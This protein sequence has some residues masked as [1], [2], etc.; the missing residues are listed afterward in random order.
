MRKRI[1]LMLV[2]TFALCQSLYAAPALPLLIEITQPDGSIIKARQ[3]GDEF[4]HWTETK[5]GYTI[6]H[7]P[8]TKYWEYAEQDAN[9]RLKSSGYRAMGQE[10]VPTHIPPRLKPPRNKKLELYRQKSLN[11]TYQERLKGAALTPSSSAFAPSPSVQRAAVGDWTPMP[12]A[13]ERKLLLVL[14]NFSDRIL[15][16]DSPDWESTVFS[17]DPTDKSVARYFAENS[18]SA[19]NVSPA[20]HRQ[21]D[22]PP[23]IIAVSI[24]A[25]HPYPSGDRDPNESYATEPGILNLALTQAATDVDFRSFD[26]DNSGTLEQSEL[27][28]YFIYAGYEASGSDKIPSVWAHAWGESGVTAGGLAVTDWAISGELNDAGRQQTMG[29]IAHELGHALCGL[30]DLYDTSYTNAGMGIFSLM[31]AGGWGADSSEDD[32]TTPTNLDLWS[33]EYLGWATAAEPGAVNAITIHPSLSAPDSGYKLQTPVSDSEYYLLENRHPAGWDLG[34]KFA[35]GAS[36]QGGLLLTHIDITAGT[37]GSNDINNFTSTGGRQGVS[38]VQASTEI[39]DMLT[40]DCWGSAPTLFYADNNSSWTPVTAPDSNYYDGQPTNFSLTGISAPLEAM[41]ATWSTTPVPPLPVIENFESGDLSKLP[42][43]TSGNG[44]WSVTGSGYN[45]IYAA[46][47]PTLV[48]TQLATLQTTVATGA[49]ALSFRYAVDSEAYYDYLIFSIDGFERGRWSGSV[50]W[51]RAVYALEAG[52]HTLTWTYEKD[53]S[54]L[55]GL[56]TA[57]IDDL[58]FPARYELNVL[59]A[60]NGTVTPDVGTLIWTG[61]TG[62]A[63][64]DNGT[65]VT[66]TANAD[67]DSTFSGWE[68]ACSGSGSCVVPMDSPKEVVAKFVITVTIPTITTF[69]LPTTSN[70]LSVGISS[71]TASDD[72]AVTGYCLAETNSSTGCAWSAAAPIGYTFASEGSKVLYAFVRDAAGN[73]SASRNANTTIDITTPTITLF[74]LPATSN[75]L[76]IA[77]DSFSVSD[78]IGVTDYCLVEINNSSACSWSPTK[79]ASYTFASDGSKVLY[80]FVR[81]IAGNISASS[82]A[83]TTIDITIPTITTFTLPA[84]SNSLSVAISSFTASDNVSVTGYCLAES[85]SSG[86]CAWSD[87]VPASYPFTS[88]GSKTLYAFARDAA[89]HISASVNASTSI[90]IYGDLNDD[91]ETTPVDALFAL[92][93]AIG[94]RIVDL[95][96]DL[97]PLID[98]SPAPD[99][100]ITAADALVILRKAVGLW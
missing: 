10:F 66:L 49:G 54:E 26:A 73:I 82:N 38:P 13:G 92:Q 89:G 29:I 74:T 1:F 63:T 95:K 3:Q 8:R 98:G 88:A 69:T 25:P 40:A 15:V 85:N 50:N 11:K 51:S 42:W 78:N 77:I 14:I 12:V 52:T 97:A 83:S 5:N 24:S 87:S 91:N 23:G 45:S 6:L 60:G 32:G 55:S 44:N 39:C 7:N 100:K 43:Q 76:G 20:D 35:L 64:Y 19:L 68:G 96:A 21:T 18:F 94:K 61:S 48:D 62:S 30:P 86:G 93:M 56:D 17:L 47:A 72:L 67:L 80:A 70:S 57:W 46:E 4:Q 22:S 90:V 27:V 59:L 58:T 31:A 37:S 16:I 34:A 71:F 81:D 53:G 75:S 33:R 2:I 65:V 79:P 41:T 28:I 84:T 99:D 9:D 36:W